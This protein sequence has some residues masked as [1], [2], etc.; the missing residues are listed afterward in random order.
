MTDYSKMVFDERTIE[1]DLREIR[2]VAPEALSRPDQHWEGN[3]ARK[4][5]IRYVFANVAAMIPHLSQ[6]LEIEFREITRL[7]DLEDNAN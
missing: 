2:I 7:I 4:R 5:L 3:E 1:G 6:E